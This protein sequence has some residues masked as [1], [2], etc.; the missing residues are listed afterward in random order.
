[1]FI[2]AAFTTTR[3]W[4]ACPRPHATWI[5]RTLEDDDGVL[6]TASGTKP[7]YTNPYGDGFTLSASLSGDRYYRLPDGSHSKTAAATSEITGVSPYA[8]P[9]VNPDSVANPFLVYIEG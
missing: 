2:S 4:A 8:L 5:T 3:S 7:L 9:V 1:M 6:A